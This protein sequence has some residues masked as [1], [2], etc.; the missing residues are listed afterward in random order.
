MAKSK[1]KT[2]Y[3]C[4]DCGAEHSKWQGQ[5]GTCSAWNTLS[6]VNVTPVASAALGYA[7]VT[8]EVKKLGDIEAVEAQRIR[9]GFTELDRVLGGGFV[10]GSVVLIGG[11]PGAG[12]STLLLQASTALAANQ[13]VLYVTGEESLQ[14]LALRA[15][16]LQLPMDGLSVAAETRAEVIAKLVETQ[17][18][19]IVIL[20]SIQVMQMESVDST[21]G[22]V[23]Q[24]RET[25]SFFTRLAKQQDIVIVLVGHITKEGGIAG[26]KVLEHMI[27]CFMMLDS[28]AGSRYRTLRGHKN[29]FGAVNE[30]GIFAM[31]DLGMKEV[32]NPSAIFLQRGDVDSP[33]SIATVTWEGTRP[34]LV[35]LQALV[36]DAAGGHPKRVAVGLDQQRL[37]M[38][39]AVLHRHCGIALSDQ[40]VFANVVGGVR[41]TET[42]A[43]LALLLAVLGSFRDR[44][45]PRELIVFGELG[46]TGE[47]RPVANGQERLREAAK[48]GFK[49]A[50]VPFANRPKEPVGSMT[51]HGVKTLPAALEVLQS[52]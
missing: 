35:E 5:C 7:G 28:P 26:P 49:A 34:L 39:L 52:L 51:V 50:I 9:S 42:G 8:A 19:K 23:T 47:L 30:L 21:P 12:K 13:G 31:T 24:V 33:G 45:L 32:A 17:R 27:D 40:D 37:A 14:Q 18:P 29:R 11:D 10:P 20:D 2:A 25:A 41:I 44:V 43:D 3:V 48:H 16:R 6:R 46:L 4:D 15:Q 22:S 38:H 1:T 36:D